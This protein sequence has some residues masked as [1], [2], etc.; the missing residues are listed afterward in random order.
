MENSCRKKHKLSSKKWISASR[1]AGLRRNSALIP[2]NAGLFHYAGNNPIRYIDPDGRITIVNENDNHVIDV[3]FN[4][5][6]SILAYPYTAD[7]NRCE[8]P[9]LY[10]GKSMYI[11]SFISPDT[12]KPV[13]IVYPNES[14]EIE[15]ACLS[16]DAIDMGYK[17]TWYESRSG[18]ELDIKARLLGHEGRSYHGFKYMGYVITLR[19]AGNIL[20]GQNAAIFKME[21]ENFQKGAGALQQNGL[22]GAFLYKSFGITYGEAPY[23][24]ENKYQY[25]CSLTGYNQVRSGKFEPVPVFEQL[26][27]LGK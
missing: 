27:L 6:T 12:G 13:G 3:K 16:M 26:L 14:I 18:G 7:G 10:Y 17:K 4:G 24:G 22:A 9:G 2:A 19:E 11:D 25:R 21:Y 5:D 1:C 20:A 23:Y 8:G 15:M